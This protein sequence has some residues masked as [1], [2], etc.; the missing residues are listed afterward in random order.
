MKVDRT[1]G[2]VGIEETD[3]TMRSV[4]L[5]DV[6]HGHWEKVVRRSAFDRLISNTDFD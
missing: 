3:G 5:A 2:F 4:R 6:V 1:L